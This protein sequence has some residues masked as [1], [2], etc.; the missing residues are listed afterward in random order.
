MP[1]P[2]SLSYLFEPASDKLGSGIAANSTRCTMIAK[3]RVKNG[4][5]VLDNGV[6][7]AEGQEVTV[8]TSTDGPASPPREGMGL[9]S[10]RD[11][12]PIS[13]RAV[14]RPFSGDDDLLG[15]MLEGR[16]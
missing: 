8:L 9:H 16:P 12:P 3:G 14:L 5:V 7:I 13:L 4:V 10:V 11:I 2:R 1:S 6:R 15:E